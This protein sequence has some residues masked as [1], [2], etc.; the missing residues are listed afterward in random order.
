MEDIWK[1]T[2]GLAK[3]RWLDLPRVSSE[4]EKEDKGLYDYESEEERQKQLKLIRHIFVPDLILRLHNTLIEQ[5]ALF[6]YFLQRAIELA[7]I[8][9]DG[10]YQVYE[11][12]LPLAAIAGGMEVVGEGEKAV[13]RLEVYMDKI[14]EVA[15]EALKSGSGT[16]FK[17]RKPA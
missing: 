8:V 13:N 11:S 15:L 7:G 3:E 1:G 5:S 14:R 10:R 4:A 2:V 9:A 12:F 16:A 17:V 6:P